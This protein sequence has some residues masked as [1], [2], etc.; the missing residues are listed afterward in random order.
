MASIFSAVIASFTL[1]VSVG[2]RPISSGYRLRAS[3]CVIVE[4]PWRLPENV[5]SAA[6]AVRFQSSPWCS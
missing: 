5:W 2:A 3:C 1:R 6:D 4:P